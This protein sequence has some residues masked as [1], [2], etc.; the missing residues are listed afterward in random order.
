MPESLGWNRNVHEALELLGVF[1][2]TRFDPLDASWRC[3]SERYME[4]H[5]GRKCAA[6]FLYYDAYTRRKVSEEVA[7]G[8][9]GVMRVVL[10]G[11]SEG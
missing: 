1:V 8:R 5:Q 11:L 10:E 6:D 7:R 4:H 9:M 3:R 2:G